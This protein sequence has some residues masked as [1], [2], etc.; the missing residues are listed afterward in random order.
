MRSGPCARLGSLALQAC[1]LGSGLLRCRFPAAQV[2]FALQLLERHPRL[3]VLFIADADQVWLRSPEGYLAQVPDADWY[4]SHDCLSHAV[5]EGQPAK[6]SARCGQIPNNHG[7][8]R[9]Q[10]GAGRL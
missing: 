10:R 1:S 3:P 4:G 7:C 8:G 2:A 6:Y 5:E 9:W